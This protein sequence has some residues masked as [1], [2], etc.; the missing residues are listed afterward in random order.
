MLNGNKYKHVLPETIRQK[1]RYSPVILEAL[2]ADF[3]VKDSLALS[4]R[5]SYGPTRHRNITGGTSQAHW[6]SSII[7]SS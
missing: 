5:L 3:V 7:A 1:R 2:A 6:D 4:M